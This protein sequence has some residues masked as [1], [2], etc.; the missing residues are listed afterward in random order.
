MVGIQPAAI[1]EQRQA[2][3]AKGAPPS[4]PPKQ[5]P[6]TDPPDAD[7]AKTIARPSPA[8]LQNLA[9]KAAAAAHGGPRAAGAPPTSNSGPLS[10]PPPALPSK[11][12]APRTGAASTPAKA[13]PGAPIALGPTPT[14]AKTPPKVTP[15]PG[16][17]AISQSSRSGLAQPPAKAAPAPT[18]ALNGNANGASE[19]FEIELDDNRPQ[20]G[21][22]DIG[23]DG[24]ADAEAALEAMQ[25][26]RLAEAA[27]Q[28]NDL[29][30]AEKLAR[31]AADG[32]PTQNDYITLLAWIRAQGNDPLLVEEAIATLSRVLADD[33]ASERAL[34]YRGK[35]LARVN[36]ANEALADLNELLASNPQHRDALAEVR[37]LKSKTT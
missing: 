18:P 17:P 35:L 12:A 34:L 37:Q 8:F 20:N 5:S 23:D 16:Q 30:A 24:L 27:L 19:D 28:R 7:G 25:S 6:S 10:R 33:A 36:R 13:V 2:G 11:V 9:K 4:E 32:D 1:L 14:P 3:A 15:P 22:V 29:V 26:F 31:K 21:A